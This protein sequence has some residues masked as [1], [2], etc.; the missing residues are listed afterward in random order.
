MALGSC[1]QEGEKTLNL[2]N[3]NQFIKWGT[4]CRFMVYGLDDKPQFPQFV[5]ITKDHLI[6][7]GH[8]GMDGGTVG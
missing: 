5:P 2:L 4:L 6:R 8:V 3:T 7:K 1:P